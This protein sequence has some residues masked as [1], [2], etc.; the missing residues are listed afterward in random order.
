MNAPPSTSSHEPSRNAERH[1]EVELRRGQVDEA[2]D[3]QAAQDA[4]HQL[5]ARDEP[6]AEQ[7]DD[8][9]DQEPDAEHHERPDALAEPRVEARDTS[10]RAVETASTQS[11]TAPQNTRVSRATSGGQDVADMPEGGARDDHGRLAA[12]LAGEGAEAERQ[13]RQGDTGEGRHDRLPQ[14]H[15][16]RQDHGADSDAHDRRVRGEPEPEHARGTAGPQ[17]EGGGLGSGVLDDEDGVVLGL[18][19]DDAGLGLGQARR[20]DRLGRER[21]GGSGGGLG[22]GCRR[23][24]EDPVDVVDGVVVLIERGGFGRLGQRGVNRR[25]VDPG[26]G[27]GRHG[28]GRGAERIGHDRRGRERRRRG[29]RRDGRRAESGRRGGSGIVRRKRSGLLPDDRA[30]AGMVMRAQQGGHR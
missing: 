30:P 1:L 12:P 27:V 8:S 24:A 7:G 19:V 13:E 25:R 29:R 6:I 20:R 21:P 16:E 18:P 3:Q 11:S 28:R 22:A 17:I 4:E 15:A 2:D 9:G 14:A 5:H 26:E 10:R 23:Q